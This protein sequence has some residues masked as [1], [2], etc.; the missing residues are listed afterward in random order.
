MNLRIIC[1]HRDF[2]ESETWRTGICRQRDQP[3]DVKTHQFVKTC[4]LF[5]IDEKFVD[6]NLFV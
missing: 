2:G 3:S 1:A 4:R 6:E 5:D